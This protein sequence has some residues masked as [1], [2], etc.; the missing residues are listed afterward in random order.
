VPFSKRWQNER[1]RNGQNI[2][3]NEKTSTEWPKRRTI[4]TESPEVRGEKKKKRQ[5]RAGASNKNQPHKK[6]P[7]KKT[8]VKCNGKPNLERNKKNIDKESTLTE[9]ELPLPETKNK[10]GLF[11]S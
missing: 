6:E 8:H 3:K 1:A 10:K 11:S 7:E 2:S 5:G 9:K 4:R